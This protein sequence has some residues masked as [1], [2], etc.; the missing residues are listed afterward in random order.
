MILNNIP[1]LLKNVLINAG[2][3]QRFNGDF[4][5]HL[6]TC[7][8]RAKNI[9]PGDIHCRAIQPDAANVQM[10]VLI[11]DL[12]QSAVIIALGHIDVGAGNPQLAVMTQ[13]LV[14]GQRTA[15]HKAIA[16]V[17][18]LFVN[19][20][21]LVHGAVRKVVELISGAFTGR[22]GRLNVG[23]RRLCRYNANGKNHDRSP[24]SECLV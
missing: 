15:E 4:R 8:R 22:K 10:G 19:L 13:K 1:I 20:R 14:I 12:K 5:Q 16:F 11:C 2:L 18:V 24:D 9:F 17:L 6:G 3:K 7:I 23:K 21:N